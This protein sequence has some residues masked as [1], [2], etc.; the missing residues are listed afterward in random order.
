MNKSPIEIAYDD[1]EHAE[2][3]IQR[4]SKQTNLRLVRKRLKLGDYQINEWLIERKTLPDLVTSLCDGRLF[5]QV[6][7]LSKSPNNTA[8]L[9]EGASRD[10][11][12]YDITREAIIGALCSISITFNVPIL[13]SLSQAESAKIIY[14]CATQLNRRKTGVISHG[15][16]PKRYKNQQ[17]FI[18][19]SLPKV[20]PKLAK[21]LLMH[22][23]SIEAVFTAS[24][25]QLSGVEGIG[26]E[27]ARQIRQILA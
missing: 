8:L 9:I 24:E 18:L 23:D 25:A 26:R 16:K 11:A 17:L 15:R 3:L 2:L 7:R 5:S 1:R 4:L 22:F 27:K 19:Q 14:F 13:R 20:G 10:I 12:A 21:R 6:S